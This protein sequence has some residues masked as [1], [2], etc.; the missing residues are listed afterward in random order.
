MAL[1]IRNHWWNDQK[2]RSVIETAGALA[3]AAWRIAVNKAIT[4]HCEAFVYTDDGQRFQVI[5]EY[6]GFLLQIADRLAYARVPEAVRKALIVEMARRCIE[7]IRDNTEDV[8]GCG[9]TW[10]QQFV[11]LLNTRSEEYA[12]FDYDVAGPSYALLRHLGFVI[13]THMGEADVNRWVI[14]QVMDRDGGD[15][16]RL[17]KKTFDSLVPD[18]APIQAESEA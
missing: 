13:Q 15:A 12:Q 1:R 6:L 18:A 11:A 16:H 14:D 4:L 2:D 9:D 17:F 5:S 10:A 7:Y 8:L 3:T